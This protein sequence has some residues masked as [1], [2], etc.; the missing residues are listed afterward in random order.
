MVDKKIPTDVSVLSGATGAS[1]TL[2]KRIP[3]KKKN[4]K[5]LAMSPPIKYPIPNPDINILG[6][7][8]DRI[9][10]PQLAKYFPGY[11]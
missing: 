8:T 11:K 6:N 3:T 10:P 5:S 9:L 7:E 1:V 2:E 4:M